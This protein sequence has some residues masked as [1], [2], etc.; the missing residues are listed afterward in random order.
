[1]PRLLRIQNADEVKSEAQRLFSTNEDARFVRRIDLMLLI[2][3]KYPLGYVSQLFGM[4]STTIQRWIHRL[5]QQGF[6]GLRD[7][8]GRG[9]KARLKDKERLRLR[10]EIERTP[11]HFGYEQARWDGKLLS[12]HLKERYGV[13]LKVRQCQYLFKELGFSLQRPRKM[14]TGGADEKREA[15]KKT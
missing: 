3:D 2:C 12:Y 5:N 7:K 9:R 1:M 11:N 15:F 6:E 10:K 14:P 4:N 8:S 13:E